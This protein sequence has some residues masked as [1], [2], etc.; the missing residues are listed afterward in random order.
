MISAILSSRGPPFRCLALAKTAAVQSVTCREILDEFAEK[1]LV[2]FGYSHEQSRAAADEIEK[3][4]AI[5]T[6]SQTLKIVADPDDDKILECAVNGKATHVVSG[7]KR[8]MLPLGS[9][10]GIAIV[11]PAQFLQLVS[12]A[13]GQPAP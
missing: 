12:G 6:I 9:Y 4:S 2:K 11:S 7:D 1:L 10:Q 3:L 13:S 8:H 5:V